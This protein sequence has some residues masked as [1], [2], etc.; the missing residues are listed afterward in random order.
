MANIQQGNFRSDNFNFAK[1]CISL[2]DRF[3]FG[4][5]VGR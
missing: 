3:D 4:T 5:R 2:L 1:M